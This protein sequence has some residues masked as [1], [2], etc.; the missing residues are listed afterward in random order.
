[1]DNQTYARV[2]EE[3]K[4]TGGFHSGSFERLT[5]DTD[6]DV[7]LKILAHFS[8]TLKESLGQVADGIQKDDAE[9]LW[10]A[11]HKIAGSAELIGFNNFGMHSRSLNLTLRAMKDLHAHA[12]EIQGYLEEGQRLV[13]QIQ[14]AFPNLKEYL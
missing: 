10:K 14:A 7:T 4:K 1:M 13:A 3:L 5:E 9:I 2:Y 6:R 8:L 12:T 11:C